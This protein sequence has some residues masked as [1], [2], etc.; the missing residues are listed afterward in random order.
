MLNLFNLLPDV[1]LG[2]LKNP[3]WSYIKD[4]LR[5]NLGTI[6]QYYRRN[7]MAVKSSHF[8]VRLLQSITVP[9]SQVLERY[10]DNVDSMALNLSMALGMTSSIFKGKIFKG[11]FY[12]PESHEILVAHNETFDPFEAHRNWKNLSPVEVL[13]HPFSD[14]SLG[15]PDGRKMGTES[16]TGLV[17][18]LINVPMLAVMYRA[19]R[20]NEM[21]VTAGEFES[22]RSIMQFIRMYVLPNMLMSHLDIAL[23]NRIDNLQKGAPMGEGL[24]KHPFYLTDHSKQINS[25]DEEILKQLNKTDH[26]FTGIL[27]SVPAAV[28]N[29][30]DEVM[31]L[32]DLAPTKQVIWALLIARL[33]A[34]SFM[35]RTTANEPGTRNRSEVNR[36]LRYF[37]HYK[38]DKLLESL[39][40]D[41]LYYDIKA[42]LDTVTRLATERNQN[43]QEENP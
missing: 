17:V 38:S 39:L 25:L 15:I 3:Q 19:F 30:M 14:L 16:G 1:G 41:Y 22:Q 18:V 8:L 21:M 13:R 5:K 32:P 6:L 20:L 37:Q 9:Q 4:G 29:N 36:T 10:Y 31:V 34:L 7:P 33:P 11:V 27:R 35:F 43:G 28:K 24:T 42:E 40:P 23:F 2:V 26:T 12:G